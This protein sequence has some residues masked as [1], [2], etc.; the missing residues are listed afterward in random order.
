MGRT[1]T[2]LP[3]EPTEEEDATEDDEIVIARWI[4]DYLEEYQ[5]AGTAQ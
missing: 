2:D 5:E 4:D 3:L 1:T